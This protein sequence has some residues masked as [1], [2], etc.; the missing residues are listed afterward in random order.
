MSTEPRSTGDDWIPLGTA[1]VFARAGDGPTQVLI[2]VA[3]EV[4][5]GCA[6]DV[7]REITAAATGADAVV[8]LSALEFVD[9]TG[10]RL[11]VELRREAEA[12]GRRLR[13]V[14]PAPRV[15][16]LLD[17]TGLRDGLLAD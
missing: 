16:R 10:I 1:R 4:D 7:K 14:D 9:S 15:L 12:D 3:G 17:M 2:A 5:I 13:Y 6:D 11:L 8:D